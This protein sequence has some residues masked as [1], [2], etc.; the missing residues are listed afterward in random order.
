LQK[1]AKTF[2]CSSQTF[3]QNFAFFCENELSQKMQKQ[4]KFCEN[5]FVEKE[6]H[7]KP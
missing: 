7:K 2:V 5:T 3:L 6:F 1:N 4:S